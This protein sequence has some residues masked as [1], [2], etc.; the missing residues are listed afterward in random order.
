[1]LLVVLLYAL[2]ASTFTIAKICLSYAK[3]FFLIAFR[4]I[5]A[6]SFMMGFLYFFKRKSFVIK[7]DD[8]WL[9]LQ[10]SIFHIYLAFVLEFW[11]LQYLSSAKTNLIYSAT[12]FVAAFF[13]YILLSEKL[14][15]KK[16]TGM[17]IGFVGLIP[18]FLTQTDVREAAME[19][20]SV[21]LPE[22]ILLLAVISGA[23]AWFIVKRLLDKGYS[24]LMINGFSMFVGG[25]F[26]LV[27]FFWFEGI[28]S[29]PIFDLWPFLGWVSLLILIAN[30]IV[31]NFYGWLLKKYSVTFVTSAGFLC[32]VFGA[33]YGY[34]F[35]S[36][37][38]TWHYF[39][40][41][42]FIC[43]GLFIFYREEIDNKNR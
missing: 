9:F 26:A 25:L 27:T 10:T 21:S 34:F 17:L 15:I 5:I 19:L 43:L 4:M 14:G 39:V 11:S 24:L 37:N 40:S 8:I 1:M 16:F 7:K 22:I 6:G 3:P 30:I 42:A 38:I 32:P 20:F 12:P 31:Y 13:A 35:L 2:L 29:S 36:E 41:F 28:E 18:I 23:Y 33:F